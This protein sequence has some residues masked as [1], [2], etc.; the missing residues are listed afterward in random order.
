MAFCHSAPQYGPPIP[1]YGAGPVYPD[2]PPVYN[3]AYG[4]ADAVSGSNFN[5]AENRNG[6]TTNGEYRVALPDGRTQIVTYQV[7]DA[8]SGYVADVKYEG[9]AIAYAP[10]RPAYG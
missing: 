5:A 1:A 10:P 4:V 7:L 2:V 9:A 6:Y 3:Y 8:T